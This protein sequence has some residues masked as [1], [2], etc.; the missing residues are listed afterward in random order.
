ME[1]F[2]CNTFKHLYNDKLIVTHVVE[3]CFLIVNMTYQV[4]KNKY[5]FP[6]G[7]L[8]DNYTFLRLTF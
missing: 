2:C 4:N 7:I 1:C 6:F 8:S 3:F 5:L